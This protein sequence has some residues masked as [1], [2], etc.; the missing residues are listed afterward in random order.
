MN[1]LRVI[2]LIKGT[3]DVLN[4]STKPNGIYFVRSTY[5][6]IIKE[7]FGGDEDLL[8]SLLWKIKV[9]P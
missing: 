8:M 7:R 4:W 2:N 1:L 5:K 9:P 6:G 3:H